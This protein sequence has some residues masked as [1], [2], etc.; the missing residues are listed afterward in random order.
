M[1]QGQEIYEIKSERV[2]VPQSQ[3]YADIRFRGNVAY[4]RV[5]GINVFLENADTGQPYDGNVLV[6][7]REIG[8]GNRIL[9]APAPYRL[10]KHSDQVSFPERFIELA[11]VKGNGCDIGISVDA[12]AIT[13]VNLA[14]TA[15]ILYS[16]N[17]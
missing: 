12:S 1:I 17:R 10:I 6:G 3:N 16:K 2:L 4:G 5:L 7:I 14:V 11:D 13:G 15:T 9:L 8:G